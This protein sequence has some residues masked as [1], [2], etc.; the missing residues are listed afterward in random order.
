MT[1]DGMPSAA[2]GRNQRQE[3]TEQTDKD[4]DTAKSA[5]RDARLVSTA[6]TPGNDCQS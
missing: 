1:G 4:E 5:W 6:R 3:T 2:C